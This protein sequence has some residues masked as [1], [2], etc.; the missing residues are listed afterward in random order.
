MNFKHYRKF[1]LSII[2]IGKKKQ[3]SFMNFEN[4]MNSIFDILE[5]STDLWIS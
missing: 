4:K 2:N 5:I 1:W 3:I